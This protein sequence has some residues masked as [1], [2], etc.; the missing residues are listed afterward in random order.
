MT[1][2]CYTSQTWYSEVIRSINKNLYTKRFTNK[3][4]T[5]REFYTD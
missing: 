4:S 3:I 1:Q 2:R 5:T